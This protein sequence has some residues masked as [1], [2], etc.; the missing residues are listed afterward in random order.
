[1]ISLQNREKQNELQ[2]TIHK[3]LKDILNK[4]IQ[5]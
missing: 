1:M 2:L 4:I 5:R 3:C